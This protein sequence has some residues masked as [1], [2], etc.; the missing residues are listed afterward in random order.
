M[1]ALKWE[2][3]SEVPP[4]TEEFMKVEFLYRPGRTHSVG[5]LDKTEKACLIRAP[6]KTGFPL[7][8][9][10]YREASITC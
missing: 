4:E 5:M 1:Q 9:N 3:N 2:H 6:L 7:R 10:K 8:Y